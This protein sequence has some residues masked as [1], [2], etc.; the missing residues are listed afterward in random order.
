[1]I[2]NPAHPNENFADKWN[3]LPVRRERFLAWL[4]RLSR[5]LLGTSRLLTESTARASIVKT[6]GIGSHSLVGVGAVVPA[7]RIR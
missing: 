3:E 1:M 4:A 2:A 7:S 6:F 5:I